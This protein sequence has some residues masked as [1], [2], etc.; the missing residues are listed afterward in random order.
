MFTSNEFYEPSA[1]AACGTIEWYIRKAL[2]EQVGRQL[3]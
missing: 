1:K 2:I 3:K